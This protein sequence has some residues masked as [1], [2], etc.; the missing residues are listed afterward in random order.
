MLSE[1]T[2]RIERHEI[3]DSD[4][5]ENNIESQRH[6]VVSVE[7]DETSRGG[8]SVKSNVRGDKFVPHKSNR[9]KSASYNSRRAKND[10]DKNEASVSKGSIGK[11]SEANPPS[12]NGVDVIGQE[13]TE[14]KDTVYVNSTKERRMSGNSEENHVEHDYHGNQDTYNQ[15]E[16]EIFSEYNDKTRADDI[17]EEEVVEDVDSEKNMSR[18]DSRNEN[19]RQKSESIDEEIPGSGYH[20]SGSADIQQRS[21]EEIVE[22]ISAAEKSESEIKTE[23]VGMDQSQNKGNGPTNGDYKTVVVITTLY[24]FYQFIVCFIFQVTVKSCS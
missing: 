7:D 22:D 15:I 11:K 4:D 16:E 13:P 1:E 14:N 8:N 6:V 2:V 23:S 17:V 21:N 5:E 18:K 20:G 9:V 10:T 24:S 19:R 12:E 3:D